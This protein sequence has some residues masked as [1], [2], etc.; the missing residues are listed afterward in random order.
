MKPK[1]AV[2]AIMA[3]AC[4]IALSCLLVGCGSSGGSAGPSESGGI[5]VSAS[6]DTKV[7]PDK[8]RISVSVVT[9]E[10]TAEACQFKNAESVNAVLEALKTQGVDEKSL[11]TS[12]SNLS[13]R[14]GNRT[15]DASGDS[16]N[17]A[18]TGSAYSE[19]VIT[20]YEMTTVLTVSDLDISNVGTLVQACVDAGANEVNGI[21]YYASNYDEAY[22]EALAQALAAAKSKAETIANATDAHLGKVTSVSEGYQD[23]SARYVSSAKEAYAM[24]DAAG[25]NGPVAETMPGQINIT[26]E[27][28][29]TYALS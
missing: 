6:S 23:T 19:W 28:T 22:N 7:V 3:L 8:A 15:T 20:G 4:S 1:N 2:L 26:A 27:V 24:E 25:G 13:A 11:Q 12:Y 5:T 17:A 16:K 21:D 10:K 18:T 9:E 14:Y 29:V